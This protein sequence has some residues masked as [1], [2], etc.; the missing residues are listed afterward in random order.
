MKA[1]VFYELGNVTMDRVM[2]VYPRHKKQVDEYAAQGK[3]RAIG[4]FKNPQKGSM[5]IF[6]DKE[7]AEAFV[8]SDPFVAEKM[9]GK[10]TIREWNETVLK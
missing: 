10:V 9:V 4:S 1:V 7:S 8:Q 5:G 6:V 2:Q 3:I